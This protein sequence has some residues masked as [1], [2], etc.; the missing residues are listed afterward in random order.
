MSD[1][2]DLVQRG[3]SA[4][5][6]LAQAKF[7]LGDLAG[8]VET[9]Y[10]GGQLQ[11][12]AEAIDIEYKTLDMYRW[13]SRAFPIG[14]GNRAKA[15]WSVYQMLAGRDDRLDILAEQDHWTVAEMRARLNKRQ[16]YYNQDDAEETSRRASVLP[17]EQRAELVREALQDPE[18]ADQVSEDIT[19]HV[20]EDPQLTD[21][22]LRKSNSNALHER[23][24]ELDKPEP[25]EKPKSKRNYEALTEQWTNLA[26]VCLAAENSGK[27]K[28]G[29]RADALMYFVGKVLGDRREPTGEQANLVNEKLDALFAEVEAYANSEAN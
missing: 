26:G 18:V 13:V 6:R 25:E 27:W 24:N 3:R 28:P 12:Y 19:D 21:E 7:D 15:S 29:A 9:S 8:E 2:N 22:V 10:G 16:N 20:A 4:K 1:W 23:D 5:E 17:V 11:A 14:I